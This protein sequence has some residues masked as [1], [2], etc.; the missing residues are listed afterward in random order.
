MSNYFNYYQPY[1]I[2]DPQTPDG[3]N[4]YR[5]ALNPPKYVPSGNY[6][7]SRTIDLQLEP[8]FDNI[9]YDKVKIYT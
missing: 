6:N 4:I 1:E 5:F 7:M 3:V 8:M 9:I 2:T